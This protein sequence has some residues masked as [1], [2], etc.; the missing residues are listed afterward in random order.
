MACRVNITDINKY[1]ETKFQEL[2]PGTIS[3]YNDESGQVELTI[4]NFQEQLDKIQEEITNTNSELNSINFGET[5]FFSDNLVIIDATEEL[6]KAMS[7]QNI[8]D[9]IQEVGVDTLWDNEY[10]VDS[11]V[12][13]ESLTQEEIKNLEIVNKTND[14]LNDIS[15][16]NTDKMSLG[17]SLSQDVDIVITSNEQDINNTVGE[18]VLQEVL[19]N[20]SDA[21]VSNAVVNNILLYRSTQ[22]DTSLINKNY[23]QELTDIASKKDIYGKVPLIEAYVL[24]KY[25]N[26]DNTTQ[27]EKIDKIY[28]TAIKELKSYVNN[29]IG[30][31]EVIGAPNSFEVDQEN[32]SKFSKEVPIIAHVRK[33]E[34]QLKRVNG[35]L[36]KFNE[37]RSDPNADKTKLKNNI[38]FYTKMKAELE[39]DLSGLRTDEYSVAYAIASDEILK[40]QNELTG[41][42]VDTEGIKDRVDSLR[43]LIKGLD[44]DFNTIPPENFKRSYASNQKLGYSELNNA[45]DELDR[46]YEIAVNKVFDKVVNSSIQYTVNVSENINPKTN[47]PYTTEELEELFRA[48]SD[49]SWFDQNLMGLGSNAFSSE[50]LTPQI[51]QSLINQKETKHATIVNSYALRL[52]KAIEKLGGSSQDFD[53]VRE[54]DSNGNETGNLIDM[55]SKSYRGFLNK[56][57]EID[58]KDTDAKSK[59]KDKIDWINEHVE[60]IDFRKL[61][62]VFDVYGVNQSEHFTATEEEMSEYEN[63]L[64]E[65][66]GDFIFEDIQKNIL[67]KLSEFEFQKDLIMDDESNMYRAST[68]AKMN[69]WTTINHIVGSNSESPFVTYTREDNATGLAIPNFN[70][71]FFTPKVKKFSS[72]VLKNSGYYNK[73]FQEMSK[74]SDKAEYWSVMRDIYKDYINPTYAEKFTSGMSLAKF[75]TTIAEEF[76]ELSFKER[77]KKLPYLTKKAGLQFKELF[78]DNQFD[79]QHDSVKRNYTDNSRN[80]INKLSYTYSNFL[81]KEELVKKAKEQ[82]IKTQVELKD[83]AGNVADVIPLETKDIARALAT[84]EVMANYSKDINK[85][86]SALLSLAGLMRAKQEVLPLARILEERDKREKGLDKKGNKVERTAQIAKTKSAI[87][88]VIIGDEE[89]Y[90]QTRYGA[91]L[92]HNLSENSFIRGIFEFLGNLPLIGKYVDVT[93]LKTYSD[94]EQHIIKILKESEKFITSGGALVPNSKF[95]YNNETYTVKDNGIITVEKVNGEESGE[96]RIIDREAYEEAFVRYIDNKIKNMGISMNVASFLDGIMK[97]FIFKSLGLNPVSGIFNRIEGKNS[98]MIMDATGHYWTPGNIDKINNFLFMGN[99][100]NISDNLGIKNI[101]LGKAKELKKLNALLRTVSITQDVKNELERQSY[102]SDVNTE[103]LLNPMQFAVDHPEFKNQSSVLLAVLMDTYISDNEGNQVPLFDGKT[104]LAWDIDKNS[105]KLILKEEFRNPVNIAN[106]ENFS[107]NEE[108]PNASNNQF[109]LAKMKMKKAIASSQGNYDKLDT[110]LGTKYI[111]GRVI[112]LFRKWLPEH[113]NQRFGSGKGIDITT[114]TQRLEGR[115]RTAFKYRGSAIPIVASTMM[116][117]YG[118]ILMPLAAVAGYMAISSYAKKKGYISVQSEANSAKLIIGTMVGTLAQYVTYPAKFFYLGDKINK[119][120]KTNIGSKV[121][122]NY[123]L[124]TANISERDANNLVSMTKELGAKMI[125]LSALLLLKSMASG[126]DDDDKMR[127][128]FYAN[129]LANMYQSL[130]MYMKPSAFM[131]QQKRLA[132]WDYL[133][134]RVLPTLEGIS[135]YSYNSLVGGDTAPSE[136]TIKKQLPKAIPLPSIVTNFV[137]GSAGWQNNT[138][139]WENNFEFESVSWIDEYAKNKKSGGQASPKKSISDYK[140][141]LK[142]KITAEEKDKGYTGEELNDR[143]F[144]RMKFELPDKQKYETDSSYWSR[145]LAGEKGTGYSAKSAQEKMRRSRKDR[146]DFQEYLDK[147]GI[148]DPDERAAK[149]RSQFGYSYDENYEGYTPVYLE[150][151]EG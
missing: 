40:L 113:I 26:L 31:N 4:P 47:E 101:P 95:K 85:T 16:S 5:V 10:K 124:E 99:A 1:V 127:D 81:P 63:S 136:R 71:I 151:P 130:D 59:Y 105:G 3:I 49:L 12:K 149:Y 45:M 42:I 84:K 121:M 114:G 15:L 133:F 90:T 102:Q 55:F 52:F 41:D 35:L 74:D 27:E 46:T 65:S 132:F 138:Y 135:S 9:E 129:Q 112:L 64:R 91:L 34:R 73:A 122:G 116:M 109:F 76:A 38:K 21:D 72:G 88:R 43:R 134:N 6:A 37:Q 110:I 2:F 82:G 86:T 145:I 30:I 39:A 69:P 143:V 58:S 53:F 51:I 144:E 150:E 57:Y 137:A 115:Y 123:F 104:F 148:T 22:S 118:G 142:S 98:A 50:T 20:I 96:N 103:S 48:T 78:H 19:P 33:S 29:L 7:L 79:Y 111:W 60:K 146:K 8:N 75:E 44:S 93:M 66:M 18:R 14:I 92:G 140:S 13:E 131:E 36:A 128:N 62:S 32:D 125:Y 87:E 56:F 70:Y 97:M 61:K 147:E 17:L 80:E 11:S 94:S 24:N 139:P 77:F 107:I 119:F 108:D 25:P 126:G 68:V 89:D 23:V 54:K 83:D 100:L 120:S 141:N 67:K 117:S 28:N 106:W